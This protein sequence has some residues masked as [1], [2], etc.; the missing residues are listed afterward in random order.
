MP[1]LQAAPHKQHVQGQNQ[2]AEMLCCL[3]WFA[4]FV[5]LAIETG[6]RAH[7]ENCPTEQDRNKTFHSFCRCLQ[8]KDCDFC[9]DNE[10]SGRGS[11]KDGKC[12]CL[13]GFTGLYCE[14][15][16]P[17]SGDSLPGLSYPL[18]PS[19]YCCVPLHVPMCPLHF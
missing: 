8:I 7:G 6:N 16:H 4:R 10:C 18:H 17:L 12:L 2:S 3:N 9:D 15:L 19:L 5:W 14:V 13:E 11:C 1:P